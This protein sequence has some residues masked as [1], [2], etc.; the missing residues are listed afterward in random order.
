MSFDNHRFTSITSLSSGDQVWVTDYSTNLIVYD[1]S[2][3]TNT[4]YTI[5][6]DKLVTVTTIENT[7]YIGVCSRKA[8]MI[9]DTSASVL[10]TLSHPAG[11]SK[12]CRIM[13]SSAT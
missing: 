8:F 2:A 3:D 7:N 10:Y 5:G 9:L 12:V 13:P 4:T 11:Q 1:I 6:S